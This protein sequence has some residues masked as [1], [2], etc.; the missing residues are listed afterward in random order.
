MRG[1]MPGTYHAYAPSSS[2]FTATTV[3]FLGMIL[4]LQ[5]V[6]RNMIF[7]PCLQPDLLPCFVASGNNVR[8]VAD[9]SLVLN[10]IGFAVC[11]A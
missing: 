10:G 1:F 7:F 2:S 4:S 11:C 5:P 9:R 8:N 3:T 6:R